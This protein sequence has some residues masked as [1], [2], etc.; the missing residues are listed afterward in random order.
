MFDGDILANI[1]LIWELNFWRNLAIKC[2]KVVWWSLSIGINSV[3]TLDERPVGTF[4]VHNHEEKN[5]ILLSNGG[6]CI[7]F[8][9][10]HIFIGSIFSFKSRA[11]SDLMFIP[12]RIFRI[13]NE[14][15]YAVDNIT[16]SFVPFD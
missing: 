8:F 3:L 1:E 10:M 2:G 11:S 15:N 13:L 7:A 14:Q 6:Y 12:W 16:Q 5:N 4:S 9:M